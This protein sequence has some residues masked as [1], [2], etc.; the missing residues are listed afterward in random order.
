VKW[1]AIANPAAGRAREAELLLRRLRELEDVD[2][3]VVHTRRPGD[4]TRLARDA[5]NFD[6]VIAIGGDG[7]IAE[8]L[9]AMDLERL[10]L[11]VLPAGH[12]N[13]LARDLGVATPARA[14]AALRSCHCRPLDLM[15]VRLEFANGRVDRRLCASTL[16]VGY[17]TDVVTRGRQRLSGLG[18]AAYAAA[19]MIV[20]PRPF[21]ARLSVED[22]AG[23]PGHYTG[24][25]INNT[26]HLANFRG[27]PDA[28]A[29][30]GVLDVMEQGHPWS[31]QLLHNFAVLAGSRAF[32]AQAMRQA[33]A[34]RLELGAAR[35]LMA[36]GELLHDVK[37]I[38]VQCRPAAVRCVVRSP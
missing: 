31:R 16:A 7:T 21:E 10:C 12:G 20:I 1:L 11:A 34:I 23:Q 29:H 33:A 36:D 25:V 4:A 6:G 14:L 9:Q 18:R 30:D 27:F 2:A 17:V 35:T 37:M 5:G 32:G 22:G 24:I 19:T 38:T 26:A 8:V 28:S 15:E 13:C 3:E